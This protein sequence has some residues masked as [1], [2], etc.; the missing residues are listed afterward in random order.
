M[1][2]LYLV[3]TYI[4]GPGQPWP[5]LEAASTLPPTVSPALGGWPSLASL[6]RRLYIVLLA[7][8]LRVPRAVTWSYLSALG[9]IL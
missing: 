3:P 2:V 5:A 1:S 6:S 4:P 8:W 9:C 7:A